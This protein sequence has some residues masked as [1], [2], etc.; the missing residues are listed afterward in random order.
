MSLFACLARAHLL[1]AARVNEL[2]LRYGLTRGMFD[3]LAALRRSGPPYCLTPKQLAG[4]LLLSG[5]GMTNRLDRLEALHLIARKPEPND[6]RS[7]LI[8]LTKQGWKLVDTILPELLEV[9]RA[10]FGFGVENGRKLTKLLSALNEQLA[11]RNGPDEE[12]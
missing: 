10:A 11:S 2:V 6:R 1:T 8:K 7:I 9:Q 3:V 5:A 12:D 4:S